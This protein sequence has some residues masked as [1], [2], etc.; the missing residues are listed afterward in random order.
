MQRAIHYGK[1]PVELAR[2]DAALAAVSSALTL[3]SS[4][5]RPGTRCT[6]N[7]RRTR[8]RPS[9]GRPCVGRRS[10][11]DRADPPGWQL[12]VHPTR[13]CDPQ[14]RDRASSSASSRAGARIWRTSLAYSTEWSTSLTIMRTMPCYARRRANTLRPRDHVAAP[15]GSAHARSPPARRS[16]HAPDRRFL[17]ALSASAQ[18][19]GPAPRDR[20]REIADTHL[21]IGP[22]EAT[23]GRHQAGNLGT[24]EEQARAAARPPAPQLRQGNGS[25]SPSGC[26]VCTGDWP[27]MPSVSSGCEP[28]LKNWCTRPRGRMRML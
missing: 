26:L 28:T 23:G 8:L 11:P 20:V 21:R 13:G 18:S 14:A 9:V 1:I 25:G 27:K 7:A 22:I 19:A 2:H 3:L 15:R 17:D 6:C 4:A 16:A 5:V 12:S 24:Q 10:A